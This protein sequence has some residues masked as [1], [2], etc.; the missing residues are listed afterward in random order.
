MRGIES[1]YINCDF[2]KLSIYYHYCY[3]TESLKLIRD[4][5]IQLKTFIEN[6]IIEKHQFDV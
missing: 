5:K 2:M 4:K 3:V 6:K 1:G